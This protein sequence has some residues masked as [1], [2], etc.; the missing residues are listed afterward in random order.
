MSLEI[1]IKSSAVMLIGSHDMGYERVVLK[2][3][4]RRS[5][6]WSGVKPQSACLLMEGEDRKGKGRDI[7]DDDLR[8]RLKP[9]PDA[10]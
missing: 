4:Y 8:E 1:E 2:S 5:A 6:G 10:C 7:F 3:R 9:C